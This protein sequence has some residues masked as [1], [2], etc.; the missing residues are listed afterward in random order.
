MIPP[1]GPTSFLFSVSVGL[2][3]AGFIC[4]VTCTYDEGENGCY[5]F[6]VSLCCVWRENTLLFDPMSKS[7]DGALYYV[8]FW[9]EN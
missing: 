3:T 8:G 6:F 9:N 7:K 4:G 5:L 2:L 1:C